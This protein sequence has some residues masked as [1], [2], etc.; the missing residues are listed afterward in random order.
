M[1]NWDNVIQW[2]I[3]NITII[4]IKKMVGIILFLVL[5]MYI[6]LLI[7]YVDMREID[8]IVRLIILVQ[9]YLLGLVMNGLTSLM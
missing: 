2:S 9:C 7:P 8:S 4:I 6:I 3:V 5:I 1:K